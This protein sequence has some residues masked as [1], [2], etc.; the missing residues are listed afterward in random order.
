LG[1][2]E[3]INNN[4]TNGKYFKFLFFILKINKLHNAILLDSQNNSKRYN[5]FN[6]AFK[7]TKIPLLTLSDFMKPLIVNFY[8]LKEKYIFGDLKFSINSNNNTI[9]VVLTRNRKKQNPV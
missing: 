7:K 3:R 4:V 6:N 1:A 5:Q 8:T 9:Y 2:Q